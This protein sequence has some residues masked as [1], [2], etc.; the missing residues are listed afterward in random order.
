MCNQSV[1]RPQN[2]EKVTLSEDHNSDTR[3][4]KNVQDKEER[5]EEQEGKD[6]GKKVTENNHW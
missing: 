3:V 4:K 6:T 2:E 5:G 1:S